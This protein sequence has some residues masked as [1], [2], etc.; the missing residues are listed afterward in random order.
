[1]HDLPTACMIEKL[2]T[3]ISK[4]IGQVKEC[5]VRIDG[6]RWGKALRILIEIDITQPITR[7][8]TINVQGVSH[9]ISL[10]ITLYFRAE[11]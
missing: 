6:T 11:K 8:R 1:M 9:W 5:D 3:E 10:D 7:G 2:G 4:I